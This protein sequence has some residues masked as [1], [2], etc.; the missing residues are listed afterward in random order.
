VTPQTPNT[1]QSQPT[2]QRRNT[3]AIVIGVILVAVS[4]F[5]LLVGISLT[6]PNDFIDFSG[7]GHFF[8]ALSLLVGCGGGWLIASGSRPADSATP[9]PPL[10]SD[11]LPPERN[12]STAH[13]AALDTAATAAS[14]T[15]NH[16]LDQVGRGEQR[17]TETATGS[18]NRG[19]L[20][21]VGLVMLAVLVAMIGTVT[22]QPPSGP[23][24]SNAQLERQLATKNGVF[25]CTTSKSTTSADTNTRTCLGSWQN[26]DCP[27]T[28]F[29]DKLAVVVTG[30]SYQ[31][32]DDQLIRQFG[33]TC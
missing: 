10:V 3:A 5:G 6:Q 18:H 12:T 25:T 7:M 31:I 26:P 11:A 13:G 22:S 4:L 9:R 28:I 15:G 1:S 2:Y 33:I 24:E 21:P 14:S 29:Y 30:G 20:V 23:A 16:D 17:A 8:V 19:L 27:G 32:T